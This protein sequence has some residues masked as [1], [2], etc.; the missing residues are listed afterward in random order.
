MIKM[1]V[2]FMIATSTAAIYTDIT[3]R[4][5]SMIGYALALLLLFASYYV[6]WSFLLFRLWIFLLSGWIVIQA[7][8]TAP[9]GRLSGHPERNI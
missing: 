7:V 3:P 5:L 6:R 9:G 1:A 2:V 4:A 8:R